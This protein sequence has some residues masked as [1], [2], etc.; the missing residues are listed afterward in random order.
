VQ[1]SI[2]TLLRSPQHRVILAFYLGMGFA[3]TIFFLNLPKPQP[4]SDAETASLPLAAGSYPWE[5]V[6]GWVISSTLLLMMFSVLGTRLA[7]ALP[8]D[9]RANWIF[10]T[11]PPH[12]P[13]DYLSARRR[14]MLAIGV[15]PVWVMT[16]IFLLSVWPW[17]AAAG[18]AIVLALAGMI[19][20]EVGLRGAQ[21]IPFTCSY[22]P[23]KS[24]FHVMFW[25]FLLV[26]LPRVIWGSSLERD[27]LESLRGYV[28]M[29]TLLTLALLGARLWT[30][31]VVTSAEAQPTFEEEDAD[32]MVALNVWDGLRNLPRDHGARQKE[33][34]G[35]PATPSPSNL[36]SSLP[37]SDETTA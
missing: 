24:S 2:R 7:F 12:E 15:L 36:S 35:R 29:L 27:A 17:R 4:S 19:F 3:L 18:H 6:S 13:A 16:T 21:K 5:D 11:T 30:R 25:V 34:G 33:R 31:R 22:L 9:L 37:F 23:G 8:L 28:V 10:R 14:S 32:R 26:V 20:A 1:F